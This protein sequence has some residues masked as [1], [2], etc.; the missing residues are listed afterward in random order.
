MAIA[1]IIYEI[2][3]TVTK[4]RLDIQRRTSSF[5]LA[6]VILFSV[7]SHFL[8]AQEKK[9][10]QA[11]RSADAVSVPLILP[12]TLDLQLLE[13]FVLMQKANAGESPAQHELGLR[14]L[15][16]RG[17]PADTMKATFWIQK[18]ADQHL[19]LAEFNLG[20]LLMNGMGTEWNPFKA[21]NHFRAAAEQENP[22]ALYVMGLLYTENFILPR[23][24]PKA[25]RYFKRA[26]ELGS[27]A[28][29]ISKKEME[30]RGM[31][32]TETADIVVPEIMRTKNNTPQTTPSDTGFSL[33]FIDFH[34]DT[35]STIEDTT[36]IREAYQGIATSS[37]AAS[38]D[39]I[40]KTKMDSSARSMFFSSAT[41]GNP[42]ALCLLGRC[43]E[44]GLN[45]QKDIILAGVYYLRALHLDS[46]RAL[47]L[48]WKLMVTDEFS[49]EL[50][51]RS[52]KNDPDALYVWSGLTSVGFNKLLN[53]K[54]AF[55]L[56]QRAASAGHVPAM[57]ELG[58]CYFTGRWAQKDSDKAIELWNRASAL[59]SL[60][61]EIRLAAANVLGQIHTQEFN[62]ALSILRAT[63]KQGS[64][65]SDLAL[66]YCYEKGI[67][68]PQDKGE[69]YRIFH[70][71][72]LRGS[73]T[74]FR[75]LR[76]MHDDIRP[77]D[78]EFQM[79]D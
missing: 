70:K 34:R 54:Q 1:L 52:S 26:S 65:F 41:A 6:A 21:F 3:H 16:G 36:L 30:R 4:M 78:K 58:L 44:R 13:A 43:Y 72:L 62:T 19:P 74:A 29:K 2:V 69:A 51:L 33:L 31:D 59:G 67:G 50:E 24:W 28:A 14:Y 64:L 63:A 76:S 55:D 60:E 47:T 27:E 32:T 61:A 7:A 75:A 39:N 17:F 12:S 9:K 57:V 5:T 25:Y 15:L 49:R 77:A 22:E 10:P 66:A 46:Y 8:Q 45:V 37:D 35:I 11:F 73:E 79:P 18:A 56:L 38:T 20:I 53:E 68:L 42:E 40:L 23:S 71:A 48:L